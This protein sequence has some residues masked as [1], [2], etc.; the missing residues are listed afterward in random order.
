MGRRRRLSVPHNRDN[1][2]ERTLLA[3]KAARPT[4][5]P[6]HRGVLRSRSGGALYAFASPPA[7]GCLFDQEPRLS[8]AATP[9]DAA[10]MM[11]PEGS[12]ELP[13]E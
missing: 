13:V 4:A 12:P 5:A 2:P 9:I 6:Q 3:W 10:C 7:A 1:G 11:G 8:R